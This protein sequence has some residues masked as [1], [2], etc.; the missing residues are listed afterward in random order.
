MRILLDTHC[1]LWMQVNPERLSGAARELITEP[2]TALYLSAASS[3]EIA[4]KWRLGKLP[5]AEPPRSYVPSRMERQGVRGLPVGHHHCLAV[6]D[7]PLHHRDPFDRML[8]AQASTERLA[9]LTA[10]RRLEPYEGVD[11]I[12]T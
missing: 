7:L 1:W 5:L 9:F 6:A 4:V 3:W 8:L 10:D 11:F 2:S 12:W